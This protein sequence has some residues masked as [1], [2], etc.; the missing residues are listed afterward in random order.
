MKQEN[1]VMTAERELPPAE[2]RRPF[3]CPVLLSA[4]LAAALLL[5]LVLYQ[6]FWGRLPERKVADSLAGNVVKDGRIDLNT[7]D[8]AALCSLPGIGEAKAQ[9]IL[10][11]REERGSFA[12]VEELLEVDGI[13]EKTLEALR[14]LLCIS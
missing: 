2:K 14:P 7:A 8:M 5:V 13:G 9:A 6:P 1:G 3:R 10:E 11:W 12:S 4:L